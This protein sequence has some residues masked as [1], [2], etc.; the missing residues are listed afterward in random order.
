MVGQSGGGWRYESRAARVESLPQRRRR[1]AQS[2]GR[3]S[4]GE[5]DRRTSANASE[6]TGGAGR[7]RAEV[8]GR[9]DSYQRLGPQLNSESLFAASGRVR[10]ATNGCRQCERLS[11][12]HPN[13]TG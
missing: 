3:E 10:L 6:L 13:P 11:T 2:D 12:S 8:T 7:S 9:I 1:G 5:S 4:V